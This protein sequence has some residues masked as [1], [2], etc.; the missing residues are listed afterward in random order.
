[1]GCSHETSPGKRDPYSWVKKHPLFMIDLHGAC[2]FRRSYSEFILP[3]QYN[4][5]LPFGEWRERSSLLHADRIDIRS[6]LIQKYDLL[7]VRRRWGGVCI[8]QILLLLSAALF[9]KLATCHVEQPRQTSTKEA[10]SFEITECPV[11]DVR[12]GCPRQAY[13]IF[14]C[15]YPADSHFT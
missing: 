14:R 6:E 12:V 4:V 5:L 13:R 3:F 11:F 8:E 15:A 9:L 2:P 1:M 7:D 10:E